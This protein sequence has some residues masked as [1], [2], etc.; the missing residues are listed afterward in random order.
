MG[1][2]FIRQIL[3]STD[4]RFGRLKVDPHTVSFFAAIMHPKLENNNQLAKEFMF[5][6]H[7]APPFV[8]LSF[9]MMI[10]CV[11]TI[12]DNDTR[13]PY[14]TGHMTYSSDMISHS[15]ISY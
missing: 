4:V 3:P 8:T 7:A 13:V 12:A 5:P 11:G 10:N 6:M 2:V 9:H 1:T 14:H 15:F